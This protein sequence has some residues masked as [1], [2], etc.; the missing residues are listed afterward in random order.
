MANNPLTPLIGVLI[1][2]AAALFT[3]Y[4]FSISNTV[5]VTLNN[6]SN[7]LW[8]IMQQMNQTAT[9]QVYVERINMAQYGQSLATAANIITPVLI[10]VAVIAYLMY[11]H[12]R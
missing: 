10:I 4:I 3:A 11:A 12:R 5:I 8:S 9:T 2:F 1:A 7:Y 6:A